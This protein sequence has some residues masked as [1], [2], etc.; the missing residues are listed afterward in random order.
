VTGR[1]HSSRCPG[2][3]APWGADTTCSP[4]PGRT[5]GTTHRTASTERTPAAR[6]SRA[7]TLRTASA[8]HSRTSDLFWKSKAVTSCLRRALGDC[9]EAS[10]TSFDMILSIRRDVSRRTDALLVAEYVASNAAAAD[11]GFRAGAPCAAWCTHCAGIPCKLSNLVCSSMV[12]TLGWLNTAHSG[13]ER[14]LEGR[15]E[16]QSLW[17]VKLDHSTRPATSSTGGRRRRW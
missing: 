7:G 5:A 16:H 8:Y 15:W 3:W 17:C 11:S 6:R 9:I 13:A 14:L 2:T 10:F 1:T 4:A 12:R